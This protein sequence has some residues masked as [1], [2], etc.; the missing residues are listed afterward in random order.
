MNKGPKI[1]VIGGVIAALAFLGAPGAVAAT[2]LSVSAA[3]KDVVVPEQWKSSTGVNATVSAEML[4]TLKFEASNADEREIGTMI[5]ELVAAEPDFA[6]AYVD[7][8]WTVGFAGKVPDAV[9][10]GL[11]GFTVVFDENLGYASAD[12]EKL[13]ETTLGSVH[14]ALPDTATVG[15]GI[16]ARTKIISINVGLVDGAD[17]ESAI[18]SALSKTDLLGFTPELAVS[19]TAGGGVDFQSYG[20]A[21]GTKITHPRATSA[22]RDS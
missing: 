6:Y 16:D 7:G 10:A 12:L 20:Q 14:A 15:G 9:R 8:T 19:V 2:S 13:V 3:P 21:S 4:D 11:S 17:E 1:F 22:P 18:D 5:S